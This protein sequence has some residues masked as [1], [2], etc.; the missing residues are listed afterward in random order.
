MS[1]QWFESEEGVP[2]PVIEGLIQIE[3]A[4]FMHEMFFGRSTRGG[5]RERETISNIKW[6]MKMWFDYLGDLKPPV[7]FA[8]AT[9][10]RHL[11]AFRESLLNGPSD[12][13]KPISFNQYY[14]TWRS[15]YS[16][17]ALKGIPTLM[18]FP[19]LVVTSS[20]ERKNNDLLAHT[21]S[22]KVV[23]TLDPGKEIVLSQTDYADRIINLEQFLALSTELGKDDPVY[24]AI[25][26]AM[27]QTGLRIEGAME[28]P[29]GP[30]GY[31]K[32]WLRY[33]EMKHKGLGHQ[34][35]HYWPK[36][37]KMITKCLVMFETM[38]SIHNIYIAKHYQD[39]YHKYEKR[40]DSP[41]LSSCLWLNKRGKPIT[42][43]DIWRAFRNASK[44]INL[45]VVPHFLRHTC[46]TYIVWNY[47]KSNDMPVNIKFAQDVYYAV[48]DQLGH[49]SIESTEIYIR[50]ILKVQAEAWLPELTPSLKEKAN[51]N[52]PE[53]VKQKLDRYFDLNE[54]G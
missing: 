46:A 14:G 5:R 47:F 34:Y 54:S 39:R 21:H 19:A 33:A 20:R 40:Y 48:K 29:V 53:K 6:H 27:L 2:I 7:S 25:A 28:W 11:Q 1:I 45:K 51:R 16:F 13:V 44:R 32:G 49:A 18:E 9:H 4:L 50:T 31:N 17:C 52:I 8:E 26:H 43:D 23:S 30:G 42:K 38:E 35:L 10:A 22:N 41:P 12:P 36:G 24:E 15:F 37:N 3:L